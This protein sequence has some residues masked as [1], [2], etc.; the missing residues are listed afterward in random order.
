MPSILEFWNF[1]NKARPQQ[2]ELCSLNFARNLSSACV[3]LCPLPTSTE[4]IQK[5]VLN[6]IE[7][8]QPAAKL[9][10]IVL[11]LASPKDKWVD[12]HP[13]RGGNNIQKGGVNNTSEPPLLPWQK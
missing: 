6:M 5:T 8:L 9:V 7:M 2:R 11:N 1:G 13:F 10:N 12:W 4:N 3:L